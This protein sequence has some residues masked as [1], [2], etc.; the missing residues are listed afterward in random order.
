MY[1]SISIALEQKTSPYKKGNQEKTPQLHAMLQ[2]NIFSKIDQDKLFK[3]K[4]DKK[5]QS[6]AG[7]AYG[8][9]YEHTDHQ[10]YYLLAVIKINIQFRPRENRG[11][12]K[13]E[14]S[15]LYSHK[16]LF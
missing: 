3:S 16:V 5:R 13:H 11:T 14:A 15:M 6:N 8:S 7:E 10:R 12:V 2:G 9:M 1:Y 4:N